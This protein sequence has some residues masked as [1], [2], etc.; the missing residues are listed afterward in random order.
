MAIFNCQGAE[1]SIGNF[2]KELIF[3][4]DNGQE[5]KES[6]GGVLRI[7][8]LKPVVSEIEIIIGDLGG[9]GF[10]SKSNAAILTNF[11]ET[12]ANRHTNKFEFVDDLGILYPQCSF[13]SDI[14]KK[15]SPNHFPENRVGLNDIKL[16]Q[17]PTVEI[18]DAVYSH[19]E[20]NLNNSITRIDCVNP[21]TGFTSDIAY[22]LQIEGE[23]IIGI[24]GGIGDEN[25]FLSCI[26]GFL[27]NGNSLAAAAHND[28]TIIAK[29]EAITAYCDTD[30]SVTID[31]VTIETKN[32]VGTLANGVVYTIA[33]GQEQI[34]GT[35]S[36]GGTAFTSC[37]RGYNNTSPSTH[38]SDV[39]V[40][41]IA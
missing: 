17:Y 10:V 11:W 40:Y 8:E 18:L 23:H 15:Y 26:R 14:T 28:N 3:Y 7:D 9:Y 39:K 38:N 32:V 6:P 34:Q 19:I 27:Y 1:I 41:K 37:S 2:A 30:G 22:I 25:T 31:A 24:K 29:R 35:Y 33:I 20:G 5:K 12:T 16:R 4:L 21:L 36:S 13:L